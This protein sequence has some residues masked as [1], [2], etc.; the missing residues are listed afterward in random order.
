MGSMS[1]GGVGVRTMSHKC[2]MYESSC[3]S[4]LVLMPEREMPL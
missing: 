3:L 4:A 2:G 1:Q